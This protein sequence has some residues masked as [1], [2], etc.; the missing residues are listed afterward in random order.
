MCDVRRLELV[1]DLYGADGYDVLETVADE[2]PDEV[3]TAMVVGHNPT[4]A[5]V[6]FLLQAEGAD[7]VRFPTS[8]IGV[9]ELDVDSWAELDGG[10]RPTRWRRT[11]ATDR[12]G[13]E[14]V[15]VRAC[16]RPSGDGRDSVS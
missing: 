10:T 5:Q 11:P 9:F 14:L 1:D 7:E 4:M 2:V 3:T 12:C 13:D 8:G 6:A 16:R 15:E